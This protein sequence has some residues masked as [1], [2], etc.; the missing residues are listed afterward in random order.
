MKLNA[1][2]HLAY[3]TN[4]HRG[5]T[6]AETLESLNKY[7]LRVRERVCPKQPYA[8]GLRL[9]NLAAHEL[10]DRDTL[11]DFQRWL[12]K[13][14]C[15]VFTVNG[16]PFERFHGAKV[17]EVCLRAGLDFAGTAYLHKFAF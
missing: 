9:S 7:A 2:L 13:N 3:C 14:Q 4:V 12:A 17:K 11:V 5:E 6:W 1:G 16:F 10:A 15:Y 8:I